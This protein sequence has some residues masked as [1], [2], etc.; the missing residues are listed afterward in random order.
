MRVGN[1]LDSGRVHIA[2]GDDGLLRSETNK[3]D[4][5]DCSCNRSNRCNGS[6]YKIDRYIHTYSLIVAV[7]TW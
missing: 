3:H 6:K 5:L 1:N 7:A 4:E 2:V